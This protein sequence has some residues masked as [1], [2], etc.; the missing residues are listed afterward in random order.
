[1]NHNYGMTKE[2]HD[3][4][5]A[6]MRRPLTNPPMQVKPRDMHPVAPSHAD[7][8]DEQIGTIDPAAIRRLIARRISRREARQGQGKAK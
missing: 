2:E 6:G 4:L 7:V 5:T 8:I 1:M 3:E